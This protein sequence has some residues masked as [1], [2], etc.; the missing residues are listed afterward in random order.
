MPWTTRSAIGWLGFRLEAWFWFLR[1]D[2]W[3]RSGRGESGAVSSAD[4]GQNFK[5]QRNQIASRL[6][7]EAFCYSFGSYKNQPSGGCIRMSFVRTFARWS[8]CSATIA[9]LVVPTFAADT[10]KKEA[11]AETTPSYYG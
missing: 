3:E 5:G 1:S 7:F 4:F 10:K 9:C 2:T 6:V 11:V 8:C